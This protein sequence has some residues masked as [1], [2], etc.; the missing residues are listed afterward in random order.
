MAQDDLDVVDGIQRIKFGEAENKRGG[1]A[2]GEDNQQRHT[3]N[4]ELALHEGPRKD[5]DDGE[6]QQSLC[7]TAGNKRGGRASRSEESAK[8]KENKHQDTISSLN[9]RK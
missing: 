5:A 8:K 6:V 7:V 3:R 1:H 4:K 2:Q 9:R